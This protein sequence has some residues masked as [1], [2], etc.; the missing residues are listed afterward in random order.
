MHDGR[1]TVAA[2]CALALFPSHA[3][4]QGVVGVT[5]ARHA[6]SA[7]VLKAD[8]GLAL[9]RAVARHVKGVRWANDSSRALR[10]RL[11]TL[12]ARVAS[13]EHRADARDIRSLRSARRDAAANGIFAQLFRRGDAT[14]AVV[15]APNRVA[16][17]LLKLPHMRAATI[18]RR[19]EDGVGCSYSSTASLP[20]DEQQIGS[21]EVFVA[22]GGCLVAVVYELGG[23]GQPPEGAA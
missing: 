14:V 13:A 21:R 11:E 23:S 17:R 15:E 1:F 5:D 8:R 12:Q 4:A 7:V 22:A 6:R 3:A 18:G 20:P 16:R 9:R 19:S 10:R 2:L